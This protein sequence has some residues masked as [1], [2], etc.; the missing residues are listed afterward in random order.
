MCGLLLN[1]RGGKVHVYVRPFRHMCMD[2]AEFLL[3][4]KHY[5]KDNIRESQIKAV[6][7]VIDDDVL[8]LDPNRLNQ[9]GI[10]YAAFARWVKAM[11]SY[12]H[13]SKVVC[14]YRE[15]LRSG[16]ADLE[17]LVAARQVAQQIER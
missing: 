17:E 6:E 8:S 2:A 1:F 9:F 13:A 7:K 10:G 12:Y 5:D 14:P 16:E 3:R 4:L 11:V 15:A